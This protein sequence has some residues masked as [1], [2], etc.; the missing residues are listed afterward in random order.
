M[1]AKHK[2]DQFT[3]AQFQKKIDDGFTA[4][5]AGEMMGIPLGTAARLATEYRQGIQKEYPES[6]EDPI[7]RGH[8]K[9]TILVEQNEQLIEQNKQL[10]AKLDSF[11]SPKTGVIKKEELVPYFDPWK[12]YVKDMFLTEENFPDL[13]KKPQKKEPIVS[14]SNTDNEL[15]IWIA[16]CDASFYTD[17]EI[18]D[19]FEG[20]TIK[21]LKKIRKLDLYKQEIKDLKKKSMTYLR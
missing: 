19:E 17:N 20:L 3:I 6:V 18:L 13:K 8:Q 5:E 16:E 9:Q 4:K 21:E 10:L 15:V 14:T 1:P 11:Q 7:P 12:I 2:Y